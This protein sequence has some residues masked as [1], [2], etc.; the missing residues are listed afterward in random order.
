[1]VTFTPEPEGIPAKCSDRTHA[2]IWLVRLG[3]VGARPAVDQLRP[4]LTGE[5]RSALDQALTGKKEKNSR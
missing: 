2:A 1:M 4:E 3:D 5:E